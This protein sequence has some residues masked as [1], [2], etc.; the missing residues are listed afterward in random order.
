MTVDTIAS[1]ARTTDP[2]KLNAFI[3]KMLGDLGAVASASLVI[4]GDKLGLY[5]ELQQGEALTSAEL[6]VRTA[7]SERYV[8]EWLA[9]PGGGR[10]RDLRPGNGALFAAARAGDGARAGRGQPSV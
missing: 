4:I 9:K 6:A 10:I 2:D 7:T 5:R 8:R 3:G 1:P